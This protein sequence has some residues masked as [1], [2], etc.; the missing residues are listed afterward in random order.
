MEEKEEY[1][2]Y[3]EKIIYFLLII[4]FVIGACICYWIFTLDA[5]DSLFEYRSVLI[6]RI[7]GLF[8]MITFPLGVIIYIMMLLS[9]KKNNELIVLKESRIDIY[10]NHP[11]LGI[12]AEIAWDE[13]TEIESRKTVNGAWA[14]D[15]YYA[16]KNIRGLKKKKKGKKIVNNS[17]GTIYRASVLLAHMDKEPQEVTEKIFEYWENYKQQTGQVT[18]TK[19]EE[20]TAYEMIEK[21]QTEE[22]E[23]TETGLK[24]GVLKAASSKKQEEL[25]K[26]IEIRRKGETFFEFMIH[27]LEQKEVEGITSQSDICK[28]Y[29]AT[30][31]R[32]KIWDNAEI[33]RELERQGYTI[34]SGMDV[35]GAVLEESE[36]KEINVQI[37]KISGFILG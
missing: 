18:E 28:I 2:V 11:Y 21:P 20:K 35:I 36:I 32:E 3:N 25:K 31:D 34:S 10:Y 12:I 19:K 27:P 14:I 16:D 15:I 1:V 37:D 13:I 29:L 8:G 7:C 24:E 6:V 9:M 23:K 4:G 30:V 17:N 5:N 33:Q 26:I 22:I